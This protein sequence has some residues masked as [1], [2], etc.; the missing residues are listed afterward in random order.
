MGIEPYTIRNHY[1]EKETKKTQIPDRIQRK[2][3]AYLPLQPRKKKK[4][5]PQM[6]SFA[7]ARKQ[8]RV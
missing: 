8:E 4:K 1:L 5:Q 2:Q 6:G 3:Q 7:R